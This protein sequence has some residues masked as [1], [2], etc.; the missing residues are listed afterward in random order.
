MLATVAWR[1]LLRHRRRTLLTVLGMALGI[2]FASLVTSISDGTYGDMID[3]AANLGT[4]HVSI[5]H[6]DYQDRPRPAHAVRLPPDMTRRAATLPEVTSVVPRIE[7]GGVAATASAAASVS[8][9]GV[10]P[11]IETA[12]TLPIF[13]GALDVGDPL[14]AVRDGVLVGERLA[15][16]LDA[17]PGRKLVV[18]VSNRDGEVVSRLVRVR[19]LLRTGAPSVDG[20]LIVISNAEL[21]GALGYTEDEFTRHA[22]LLSDHRAAPAVTAELERWLPADASALRW[23]EAQPELAQFIAIDGTAGQ[24]IE[25]LVLL[26]LTAGV[27][28]TML[29][30]VMERTRELGV[31]RAIGFS[32]GQIFRMVTWEGLWLG[33]LGVAVGLLVWW[34]LYAVLSE[35][36]I[37]MS[38]LVPPNSEIAGVAMSPVMTVKIRATRLLFICGICLA[39]TLLAGLYPA[40]RASRLCPVDAM[41]GES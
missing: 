5:Q 27:F 21:Q 33:T 39:A 38:S 30:S 17:R 24:L 28:N 31:L 1:N 32:G 41:R 29:V 11:A 14:A 26:M 36:G 13:V 3:H 15:T 34:P 2:V 16:R 35:R 8:L 9:L 12:E 10:D 6:P 20:G 37:D 40:R 25:L 23:D 7:A 19:G 4:G 22:V 18:T